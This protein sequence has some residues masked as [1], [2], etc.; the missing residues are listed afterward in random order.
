MSFPK[1][2]PGQRMSAAF[3]EGPTIEV[4]LDLHCPFC[5]KAY[6]KLKEL[7]GHYGEERLQVV[8]FNWVQP[9]HAQATWL[10]QA[11]LAASMFE[12]KSM[13]WKM[14]D[15]LYEHQDE[16]SD[17]KTENMSKADMFNVLTDYAGSLG[18]DKETFAANLRS[19]QVIQLMKWELKYGR[20][21]GIHSSPTFM[22]N[23]LLAPNLSSGT[24]IEQWKE[25][26]DPLMP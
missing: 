25:F 21:N 5:K 7:V 3:K 13:Y 12:D 15:L 18:M 2:F 8:M 1:Q 16:F 20:Q 22:V 24:S 26:L 10:H 4:F 6:P 23:G 9:W 11:A 19:N 17:E 14:V